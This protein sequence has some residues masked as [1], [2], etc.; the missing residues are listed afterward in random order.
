MTD[1]GINLMASAHD[2]RAQLRRGAPPVELPRR[3]AGLGPTVGLHPAVRRESDP[4][5]HFRRMVI[6]VTALCL[7]AD[8]RLHAAA[9]HRHGGHAAGGLH[10]DGEVQGHQRRRVLWRHALRPSSL[11]LLTVAG[12]NVGALIGGSIVIEYLLSIPGMGYSARRRRQRPPV[13]DAPEPRGP[14]RHRLRADQLPHRLPVH[15]ARPPH[16]GACLVTHLEPS[17]IT[18]EPTR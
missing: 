16:P 9:A 8:R 13:R 5:D 14:H 7:G 17:V 11:T 12:L 18:L 6:P 15:R 4:A 1:R 3:P 10:P 2:R